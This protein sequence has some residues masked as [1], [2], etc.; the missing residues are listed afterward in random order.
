VVL[1]V[2]ALRFTVGGA[3]ADSAGIDLASVALGV[4]SWFMTV[5]AVYLLNGI[6]DIAGDR[7]NGSKRP[8]ATGELERSA[9][10]AW[11]IALSTCAI[12]LGSLVGWIFVLLVC[13][14]L[15]F[16]AAYSLGPFAAKKWGIPALTVA[17]IGSFITYLAG[18]IAFDAVATVPLLGFDT[19]MSCWIL[20]VGHTKDFGDVRG[21]RVMGRRTLPLVLGEQS[22]RRLVAAGATIVAACGAVAA[23]LN[24]SLIPLALLAPASGFIA[25]CAARSDL[26]RCQKSVRRPYRVFMLAQYSTNIGV[27]FVAVALTSQL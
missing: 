17:A 11:C 1:G 16:G 19:V 27:L 24:S 22:A 13:A 14:M 4:A 2:F 12:V 26:S 7:A 10:L 15:A 9:A 3:L 23:A 18:A 25:V 8:L 5:W 21:D 6:S 20:M